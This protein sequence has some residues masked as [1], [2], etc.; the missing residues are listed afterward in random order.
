MRTRDEL[1]R[2]RAENAALRAEN[3][4]LRAMQPMLDVLDQEDATTTTVVARIH[5]WSFPCV[6]SAD[7]PPFTAERKR[8]A[9]RL[10]RADRI[11]PLPSIAARQ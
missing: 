11:C 7:A 8:L 10:L 4:R 9:R 5:H 3:E 1:A 2:L 6:A